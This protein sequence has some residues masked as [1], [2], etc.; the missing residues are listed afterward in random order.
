MR[1]E[2]GVWWG[3]AGFW[4]GGQREGDRRGYLSIFWDNPR[5][6]DFEASHVH[7]IDCCPGWVASF[8]RFDGAT[9]PYN[10]ASAACWAGDSPGA[11][12]SAWARL[13]WTMPSDMSTTSVIGVTKYYVR[14]RISVIF[15]TAPILSRGHVGG[16]LTTFD[17]AGNAADA[18]INPYRDA[19]SLTP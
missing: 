11:R 4:N 7:T 5:Y 16:W 8:P 17:A 14:M 6:G 13:T 18:G 9:D 1:V 2:S 3:V 12:R 10:G 15:T 19:L